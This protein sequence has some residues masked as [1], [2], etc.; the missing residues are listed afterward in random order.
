MTECTKIT[1]ENYSSFEPLMSNSMKNMLKNEETYAIG[2]VWN[3]EAVGVMLIRET[4]M[5]VYI[6]DFCVADIFKIHAEIEDSMHNEVLKKAAEAGKIVQAIFEAE[7][8]DDYK[9]AVYNDNLNFGIEKE[10]GY[11]CYVESEDLKPLMEKY[12]NKDRGKVYKFNDLP[13]TMRKAFIKEITEEGVNYLDDSNPMNI[14][15]LCLCKTEDN[16]IVSAIFVKYYGKYNDRLELSYMYC[17]KGYEVDFIY[18]ICEAYHRLSLTEDNDM[19]IYISAINDATVKLVEKLIPS[20]VVVS[21]FYT[22]YELVF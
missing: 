12:G 19:R 20:R 18:L 10:E 9:Y 2:A 21:E 5:M 17:K 3:G 13:G 8:T 14:D 4:D 7:S 1:K 15:D 22:A 6:L 16:K 11:K